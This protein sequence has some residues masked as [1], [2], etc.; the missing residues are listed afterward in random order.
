MLIIG[1]WNPIYACV[2]TIFSHGNINYIEEVYKEK[3]DINDFRIDLT[4]LY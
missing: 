2:Y 1:D 3:M 4:F